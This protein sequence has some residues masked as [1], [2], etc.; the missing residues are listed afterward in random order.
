MRFSQAYPEKG[1][2]NYKVPGTRGWGVRPLL[3]NITSHPKVRMVA[4]LSTDKQEGQGVIHHPATSDGGRA[5][6]F[7][8]MPKPSQQHLRKMQSVPQGSS[9]S[10][11]GGGGRQRPS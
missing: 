5:P 3:P 1:F 10:S 7:V 6:V 4:V 8:T 11:F 2:V 9:A